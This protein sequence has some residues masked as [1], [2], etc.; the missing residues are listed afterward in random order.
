MK[1]IVLVG[2][3]NPP[4]KWN[5]RADTSSLDGVLRKSGT[6]VSNEIL[7]LF[8]CKP[9]TQVSENERTYNART[10][11]PIMV[12]TTFLVKAFC[13]PMLRVS[14]LSPRWSNFLALRDCERD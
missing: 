1:P 10:P 9:W 8:R 14:M 12:I 6:R 4:V 5:G 11:N 13:T 2:K 3:P 7:W